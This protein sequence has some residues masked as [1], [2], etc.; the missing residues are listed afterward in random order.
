MRGRGAAIAAQW[1]EATMLETAA[2][3]GTTQLSRAAALPDRVRASPFRVA[4]LEGVRQRN[5]ALDAL[6][7][8]VARVTQE[9]AERL[10]PW[11]AAEGALLIVPPT[12][13]GPLTLCPTLDDF[14]AEHG[15]DVR[16]LTV[17]G[18]GSSALGSAA[19]ARNVA[20]A[21]ARPVAAVV[22]GYG[23]A[24]VMTEALGGFFWF[25]A[26]NSARHLFEMIDLW[27]ES[28]SRAERSLQAA[29]G[30]DTVAESRDTRTV[31]A[32]LRDPRFEFNLMVGHSKGNLVLA[33]AL[34]DLKAADRPRL[35]ALAA[36]T[37][38]VTI[39]ARIAMPLPFRDVIDVMGE[40]DWFGTL[41]SRGDIPA[42]HVVPGAFHH[43]NTEIVGHLPVT[44]TLRQVLKPEPAELR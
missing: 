25:G 29:L 21:I 9:E 23:L 24:D 10:A 4:A 26:L 30:G 33:E 35:A 39:S 20:D 1:L 2:T 5:A 40:W 27:T 16:T 31:L 6:F 34:F 13:A 37:R 3:L 14:I 7:Y 11:I 28:D 44:A 43:T 42:D 19:F 38:I 18:V 22:S 8:D 17:A 36:T 15:A 12:G 32:L 41:N